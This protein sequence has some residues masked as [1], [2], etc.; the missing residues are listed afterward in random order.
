MN[1]QCNN[2]QREFEVAVIPGQVEITSGPSHRWQEGWPDEIEPAKCE[3][4]HEVN[5]DRVMQYYE[6]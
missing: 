3:C 4:G 5:E 6:N 1:Y 2:C